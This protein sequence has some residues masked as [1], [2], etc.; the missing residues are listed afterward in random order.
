MA[1]PCSVSHCCDSNNINLFKCSGVCDK[2]FHAKCAKI[3]Q[4]MADRVIASDSGIYWY[5]V[6]CRNVNLFAM[7]F[8]LSRMGDEFSRLSKDFLNVSKDLASI[9]DT[10]NKIKEFPN[11]VPE[12]VIPGSVDVTH[13]VTIPF[14]ISSSSFN[15][16][17]PPV[18]N[19]NFSNVTVRKKKVAS[20]SPVT[21]IDMSKPTVRKKKNKTP[22]SSSGNLT[23]TISN[24]SNINIGSDV[25]NQL[26]SLQA[27]SPSKTLFISKLVK[28]ITPED[29]L[30]HIRGLLSKSVNFTNV[31]FECIKCYKISK[32]DS[33]VSSFKISVPSNIF[34]FLLS[35]SVWP[36]HTLVKEFVSNNSRNRAVVPNVVSS[37]CK[38]N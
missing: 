16:G 38:K 26:T 7:S 8:K 3:T 15:T 23:S 4:P 29:V 1:S 6:D 30:H 24:N 12:I 21:S 13:N 31:N 5:C 18:T 10:F 9:Q 20:N 27:I 37:Q 22:T 14:P 11:G 2:T 19:T 35:P 36:T 32:K 17:N 33:F 34:S 25:D 28:S